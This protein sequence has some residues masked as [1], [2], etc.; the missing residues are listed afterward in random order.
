MIK[1]HLV[2]DIETFY[3]KEFSL[4][5]MDVPSY[6]LDPRFQV[7]LLGVWDVRKHSE[8]VILEA[9]EVPDFLAQY[10]PEETAAG[11]HNAL[12]DMAI[13]A[14]RYNW[15][16][17]RLFDTLSMA[18]ALL[19][20]KRNDLGS[21]AQHLELGEKGDTIVKVQG[22]SADAIKHAGLW[23]AYKR[24]LYIDVVQCAGIYAKLLPSLPP[25]ERLVMDLVLRCAIE[26]VFHADTK[27]L[28][29]HLHQLREHKR[30]LLQDCGYDK[31]QLMSTAAFKT[32]LEQLGVVV[33]TKPSPTNPDKQLPCFAKTDAFMAKLQEYDG[34]LDPD[35]N[36]RV[37]TLAMARLAHKSTIEETRTEKF[38]NVATLPWGNGA[39][40]P[41]ALRYGG[42]HTHRLSGEWGMNLQNL[43]RDKSKSKLRKSLIAPPGHQ[44]VTADLS[45]IEARL[46]ARFCNQE[47]LLEQFA[48]GEDVYAS[49]AGLVFDRPIS[50]DDNPVERFLGKTATLGLGYRCGHERFYYMATTQARQ[51][52]IPL[53]LDIE[54]AARV[55]KT[56]RNTFQQIPR[57]WYALDRHVQTVLLDR[58]EDQFV[59]LHP[60]KISSGKITLPNGM[61]LLY[62]LDN[63]NHLHGGLVLENVI[64][65]LAR[66]VLMQAAIRLYLR[67]LRFVLQVHDEL[68]FIIP[69]DDIENAKL[70]I[71]EEMTRQPSWIG[72][73]PLAVEIGVGSNYA[74]TK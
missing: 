31:A 60:I 69:N 49:F 28:Y 62:D 70:V 6:V 66:I 25:E 20:L 32:A 38:L 10:P 34:D 33:E 21:V 46:N 35:I 65:A 23:D 17:R 58:K 42:A 3:S 5:K 41:I 53:Q 51:A 39:M 27:L 63:S 43:P 57:T 45:Q 56:Y 9:H 29:V 68:V 67:G 55:V 64:Q 52:G 24:Y 72:P 48:A 15:V 19:R 37:Q 30:R 36:L 61:N 14:W 59:E 4:R 54:M 40:L 74:E 18:R 22:L 26:P 16:P 8:P 44:V 11:S 47:D 1:H 73:V 13:L 71:M 2:L 7:H 50:K 12:F